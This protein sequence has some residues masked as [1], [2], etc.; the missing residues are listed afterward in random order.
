MSNS[1]FIPYGKHFL[2]QD[3]IDSVV[4]VLKNGMLTQGPKIEE[5]E[6]LVAK[7]VNAKYA[8]AVSSGTAALHLACKVVGLTSGDQIITSANTFV[9]S[10]NAAEYLNASPYFCDIDNNTLN[11]SISDL[12]D[13]LKQLD[14]CK[15]VMPVH[16]AGAPCEL[17]EIQKISKKENMIIIEDASHALGTCYESGELVGSCKFSDM[18][19]FSLHPVKGVTA[20]EGGVITTNNID[21]AKKLRLLRS[22]GI[23]KGN[24][25]LP[26]ISKGDD[27]IKNK[28]EAFNDGE[29]NPWY[30]E[31]QSLG[32]N[33]RITDI[34]SALAIS[35]LKKIDK[36]IKRRRE[37]AEIYDQELKDQDLIKRTQLKLRNYSSHH[38]YV[39]R[40]N[41]DKI[42]LSKRLL[43]N[44]LFEN[45]IG[46]QVHYIPVPMHPY[47][48]SKGFSIND[49]PNT[50]SYYE[51][52][53]SL[54]I[55]YG[56]TDELIQ[57]VVQTTFDIIS[58][59]N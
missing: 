3:D 6:N 57:K 49:Y 2:D 31:M 50:K 37:I 38:L 33:Y 30:Y 51:E 13:K 12:T 16:F 20:G 22:H 8:V 42:K 46:T 25:D 27:M 18:T 21:F 55:Y 40:F 58:S 54:P 32:Y 1:N 19:T 7:K 5:F 9:A 48:Q 11:M 41:F 59:Q 43:M 10:A 15:I 47:Y 28:K 29:L 52:A 23:L 45:G 56:L 14:N 35:Q 44:K 4:E 39:V 36:F 53:L 17:S 34:Q 26:G 24:F